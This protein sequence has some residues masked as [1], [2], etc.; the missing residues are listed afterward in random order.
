MSVK[1]PIVAITG[2][3]GAGTTSVM[4][5]FEQIFRREGVTAA[6]LEGDSFHRYDRAE[7]KRKMAA[8][9]E[10]GNHDFSHFGPE[11]NLFEELAELFRAYGE[12]GQG[13]RR[14]SLHDGEEARPPG[15]EPV[16]YTPREHPPENTAGMLY[17]DIQG[18]VATHEV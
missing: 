8:E 17:E 11:A 6:F 14:K 15:K 18:G 12:T 10:R 7:M 5:T 1:H 13:R 16:T 2:S 9:V 4:R 3:S